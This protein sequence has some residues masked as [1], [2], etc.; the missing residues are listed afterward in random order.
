MLD[1]GDPK[2]NDWCSYRKRKCLAKTDT[3]GPRPETTEAPSRVVPQGHQR[4]P[5]TARFWKRPGKI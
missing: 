5:A 1:E 4:L 3:K 2:S